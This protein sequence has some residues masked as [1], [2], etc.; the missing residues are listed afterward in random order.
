MSDPAHKIIIITAPSGSGKTSITRHLMEQFP[1][2][3]FSVSATTRPPRP[4][5]TNGIDY[6]YLSTE[7]FKEKIQ[8]ADFIEYEM[9]YEGLYYGTLK[10]ELNRIWSNGQ[11]PV[12]DIDVK[13]AM[14]V[15]KLYPGKTLSLFIEPPSIQELEFRL[16]K[17]GTETEESLLKR[18]S[19]A[20]AEME[21]K[22][23][24]DIVIIN[25]D[26]QIACKQ[27]RTEVGAF[28]KQ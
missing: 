23:N 13:G 8:S 25:D 6:Y 11:I 1:E 5:E 16:R 27:A 17:R 24:F 18:L 14:N 21:Y 9:V 22:N 19:K 12:L 4:K 20:T 10:S 15:K 28:I 26:L 2:L 3:S 7:A